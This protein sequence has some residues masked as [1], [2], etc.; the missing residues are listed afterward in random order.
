MKRSTGFLY[1]LILITY[2]KQNKPNIRFNA[3]RF[4]SAS[5]N[6]PDRKRV[7]LSGCFLPLPCKQF[8]QAFYK[9]GGVF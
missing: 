8:V 1:K 7:F 6:N 2:L 9:V 3:A 5:G 4:F